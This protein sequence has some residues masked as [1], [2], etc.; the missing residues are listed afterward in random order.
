MRKESPCSRLNFYLT[1][2]FFLAVLLLSD[3]V[4]AIKSEHLSPA[5]RRFR[6][7]LE[8]G[9]GKGRT[10]ARRVS[11]EPIGG[12]PAASSSP[13]H[14]T[15]DLKSTSGHY[16]HV[17]HFKHRQIEDESCNNITITPPGFDGSC[18]V[19]QPCPNGACWCVAQ[20]GLPVY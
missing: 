6:R 19:L 17:P 7:R 1:V 8:A 14:T 2:L 9:E 20:S 12:S 15:K 16:D 3:D 5:A 4:A 11:T 18:S 13:F 10:V